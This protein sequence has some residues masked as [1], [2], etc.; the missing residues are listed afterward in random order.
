MVEL[1]SGRMTLEPEFITTVFM[2]RI[3]GQDLPREKGKQKPNY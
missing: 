1:V 2:G 3:L